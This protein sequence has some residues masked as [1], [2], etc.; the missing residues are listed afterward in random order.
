MGLMMSSEACNIVARSN[1]LAV[2]SLALLTIVLG[3]FYRSFLVFRFFSLPL[4]AFSLRFSFNPRDC[5]GYDFSFLPTITYARRRIYGIKHERPSSI[6]SKIQNKFAD[7][8]GE[9]RDGTIRIDKRNL[10]RTADLAY[11][12]ESCLRA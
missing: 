4:A 9:E 7:A 3:T 10:L 11:P 6:A 2:R 12:L 1:A 8:S 5:N